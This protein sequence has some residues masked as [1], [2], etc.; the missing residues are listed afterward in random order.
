MSPFVFPLSA[1]TWVHNPTVIGSVTLR[2]GPRRFCPHHSDH[3]RA[4]MLNHS[5][6]Y[7]AP[8]LTCQN[9]QCYERCNK[10][11]S[12]F[13][14]HGSLTVRTWSTEPRGHHVTCAL[15]GICCK[16]AAFNYTLNSALNDAGVRAGGYKQNLYPKGQ[17]KTCYQECGCH[18]LL[19]LAIMLLLSASK[20]RSHITLQQ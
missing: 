15:I 2:K 20:G 16:L 14:R 10:V 8:M 9:P 4:L 13:R 7:R 17:S 6:H 11:L 3:C 19:L 5:D 18:L 12:S 1:I